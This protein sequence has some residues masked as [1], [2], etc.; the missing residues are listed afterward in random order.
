MSSNMRISIFYFLIIFLLSGSCASNKMNMVN[1]KDRDSQNKFTQTLELYS[2]T[3][4]PNG[5]QKKQTIFNSKKVQREKEF[6]AVLGTIPKPKEPVPPLSEGT[7]A[8]VVLRKAVELYNQ[9]IIEL[10]NKLKQININEKG[11]EEDYTNLLIE[12]NNLICY[13]QEG[14]T[15]L[16]KKVQRLFGDVSF[17]TA[18]SDVSVDGKKSISSISMNINSEVDKWR[19]YVNSCNKKIFE[20]DLFV[21]VINIDGY[22]DQRG[23][24]PSNQVLS[25]KRA[26]AVEKEL[27]NELLKLVKEQKVKIVFDR[28]YTKGH[29]EKLPPGVVQGPQ[30]DPNRRVCVIS[31]IVG[32]SRYIGAN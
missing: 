5:G 31:Y 9:K 2:P 18:S 25:E 15:L 11:S 16:E 27:R 7:E 1:V 30:D 26:K 8:D 10:E 3:Y 17:Q 32:P 21:V 14:L 19:K 4:E 13:Y 24:E 22:A 29:G 12:I 28:I 20:N 23:S 6:M